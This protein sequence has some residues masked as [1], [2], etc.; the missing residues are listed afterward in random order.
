MNLRA[1][2]TSAQRAPIG[3]GLIRRRLPFYSRFHTNGAAGVDVFSHNVNHIP[4][5]LRKCLGYCFPQPVLSGSSVG[6][7]K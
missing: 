6:A 2:D 7:N 5:S 3:G 4:G 1:T